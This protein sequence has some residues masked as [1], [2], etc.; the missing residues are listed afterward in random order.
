MRTR[1]GSSCRDRRTSILG[2]LRPRLCLL[3]AALLFTTVAAPARA[4]VQDALVAFDRGDYEKAFEEF[5][6]LARAGDPVAQFFV[7][8]MYDLGEGVAQ[9]DVGAVE[10]YS[11]SAEQGIAE[12]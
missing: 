6:P 10:W 11:H 12:A 1:T 9:D 3:L 7:G 2:S 5:L 4:G 8:L